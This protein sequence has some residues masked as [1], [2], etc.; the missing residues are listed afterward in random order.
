MWFNINEL[1]AENYFIFEQNFKGK[2]YPF[3]DLLKQWIITFI[4]GTD[5]L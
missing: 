3:I 1:S 5:T 2:I 4:S